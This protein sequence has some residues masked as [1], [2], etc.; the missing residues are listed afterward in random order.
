MILSER[1]LELVG[2]Q[3]IMVLSDDSR[4][5]RR[6]PTCCRSDDILEIETL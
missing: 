3:R 2:P 6:S 5:G 4:P 1:E